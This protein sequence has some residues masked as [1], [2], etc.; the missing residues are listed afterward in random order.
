MPFP[1][2]ENYRR[3][4]LLLCVLERVHASATAVIFCSCIKKPFLR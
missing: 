3:K 1:N 2:D 4:L